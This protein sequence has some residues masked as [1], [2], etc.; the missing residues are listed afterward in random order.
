[1]PRKGKNKRKTLSPPEENQGEDNTTCGYCSQPY[2]GNNDGMICCDD[3]DKWIH[4]KCAEV[5][6]D[7]LDQE[8][9]WFCQDCVKKADEARGGGKSGEEDS[10]ESVT[11]QMIEQFR[12]GMATMTSD[13]EKLRK[14]NEDLKAAVEREK[15]DKVTHV[16]PNLN[17]PQEVQKNYDIIKGMSELLTMLTDAGYNTPLPTP[18]PDNQPPRRQEPPRFPNVDRRT[19]EEF[20]TNSV[21][22]ASVNDAIGKLARC[23]MQ[24]QMADLPIFDGKDRKLWADFESEYRIS[25]KDGEL[26]EQTNMQ[27]LRKS[28][29]SPARD[30]VAEELLGTS[31]TSVMETLKYFYGRPEVI[32]PELV[33][34]LRESAEVKNGF[35]PKLKQLSLKLSRYI[36]VLKDMNLESQLTDLTL[37]HILLDKLKQN[38]SIYSKWNEMKMVTPTLNLRDLDTFLKNKWI[39][40]PADMIDTEVKSSSS[41]ANSRR[42]RSVMSHMVVSTN[43]SNSNRS[44][45]VACGED[46]RV[47]KCDQFKAKSVPDREKVVR[48]KNLCFCCLSF[49]HMAKDCN[50][51]R[52]CNIDGCEKFHSRF[53]HIKKNQN[54][55]PAENN[56]VNPQPANLPVVKPPAV[57][58]TQMISEKSKLLM[59]MAFMKCYGPKGSSIELVFLDDGSQVTAVENS[60]I[61]DLG[62]EGTPETLTL[63]WTGMT[64]RQEAATVFNMAISSPDKSKRYTFGNIYAVEDLSLPYQLQ[65]AEE[66]KK[67]YKHL[68][69]LKIPS[70]MNKRPRILIGVDQALF[71]GGSKL[72]KGKNHEEPIA[73]D[74]K[75]GWVVYGRTKVGGSSAEFMGCHLQVLSKTE[76]KPVVIRNYFEESRADAELHDL[77]LKH[78]TT[79]NFGVLPN[80][81]I[82]KSREDERA[83][84]IMKKTLN[85][86][87]GRYEIGLLWKDDDVKLPESYNMAFSRLRKSEAMM[88]KKPELREWLNNHIQSIVDKDYARLATEEE[89]NAEYERTWHC[90]MFVTYNQNKL[91]PKPRLVW[92][93]AATSH[94]VSLNS[95][96]LSGPDNLA[97]L[98]AGLMR[99]REERYA[100]NAD[101]REMFP[102]VKIRYPDYHCQRFL[103]RNCDQSKMPNIY[104]MTSMLFGPTCSPSISQFIKN[105]HAEKYRDEFP[106]AVEGLQKFTYMDDYFNSHPTP[107]EAARVT[108]NAV[109]ICDDMSWQLVGIQSNSKEVLQQM[110]KENV[111]EQLINLDSDLNPVYVTKVLGMHWDAVND[112]FLYKRKQDELMEKVCDPSYRPT[113]REILRIIMRTFDPLGLISKYLIQGKMVMQDVWIEGIGWDDIINEEINYRWQ[114]FIKSFDEIEKIRIDRQYADVE[115]KKCEVYLV[116]FVDAGEGAFAAVSYFRFVTPEGKV[117]VGLASAKAKVAPINTLSIPK[118]ELQGGLLGS[119]LDATVTKL[120]SFEISRHIFLTD[121]QCVLS[122]ISNPK[123]KKDK[124]IGSRIGEILENT[125]S[126]DW[127]YVPSKLNVADEATKWTKPE[128]DVENSRWFKGPDFLLKPFEEWPIQKYQVPVVNTHFIIKEKLDLFA[129]LPSH[130]KY[131]WKRLVHTVSLFLRIMKPKEQR[132]RFQYIQAE[133]FQRAELTVFRKIQS[134]AFSDEVDSLKR[135]KKLPEERRNDV[136]CIISSSRLAKLKVF[137]DDDDIIRSVSKNQRADQSYAAR[138]P[139]VL[140]SKHPLVDVFVKYFHERNRHYLKE[141]TIAEIRKVAWVIAVRRTLLRVISR[142]GECKIKSAKPV[143]PEEGYLH[144]SR[145]DFEKPPFTNLGIDVFGPVYIKQGRSEVKRWVVLFTCL[146]FRAIRLEVVKDMTADRMIGAIRRATGRY[147]KVE[148][149]WSDNGS[150]FLGANNE[151][152][153]N[154]E[155]VQEVYGKA[156]ADELKVDWKFI[157]AYSP[158]MGGAWERL[159]G[160]TKRVLNNILQDETPDEWVL[161][162][163]LMEVEIMMNN[164]PLTHTPTDPEELQPLT[165][166]TMMFGTHIRAA[167]NIN[168]VDSSHRY[169]RKNYLKAQELGERLGARWMKEFWPE[170]SRRAQKSLNR[171]NMQV[172]DIVLVTEPNLPRSD[173]KMGRVINIHPTRDGIARSVDVKFKDG[174]VVLKRSVGRCALVDIRGDESTP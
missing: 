133:E 96:L 159:I 68:R 46:H 86:V 109:K 97:P 171:K 163:A 170:I 27:R 152:K 33:K 153:R 139:P 100:V 158:W 141:E 69:G 18:E 101:V 60:L 54:R 132:P 12:S 140:P 169:S 104:I 89:L 16:L 91:P 103:W 148:K 115:P 121:S 73:A 173:W 39:Y 134:E 120:T 38:Y 9:P 124:F 47:W 40:M 75:L 6:Q 30:N 29:K 41:S 150:N 76:K 20:D 28:L 45:C 1:M 136:N 24:G 14:E 155:E 162:D 53:L 5:D 143:M 161:I 147:T 112:K 3:C 32:L 8:E 127:F 2:L 15:A 52:K 131:D 90:P 19:V 125:S 110:P 78:M 22:S 56:V 81:K 138:N 135:W 166:N 65:D 92:D 82:V 71:L 123:F 157:C 55:T 142:C 70:I 116:T 168:A 85:F 105:F 111:K 174:S 160:I 167:R 126:A 4:F 94:D 137:L 145:Q 87:D 164:R 77:V 34:D 156:A 129:R 114:V 61:E 83:E 17:N 44:S 10:G 66:L 48:D 63:Q 84:E 62:I 93:V 113:K 99:F 154:V 74:T 130:L 107:E 36:R 128:D 172:D 11:L 26:D 43:S 80:A 88:R 42:N 23:V 58:L 13:M 57:N 108:I 64:T 79:E 50:R 122:W 95:C 7:S 31:A 37:E 149:I 165:P 49:D 98:L 144:Q 59:K 25:T 118:L 51:K 67:A 146:T 106:E 119:R 21:A 72:I 35:D 151:L 102:Q 117:Y